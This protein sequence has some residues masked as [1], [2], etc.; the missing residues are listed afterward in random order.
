MA[1]MVTTV[2]RQA[3]ISEVLAPALLRSSVTPSHR[4]RWKLIFARAGFLRGFAFRSTVSIT[5]DLPLESV[6]HN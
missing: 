2:L 4:T 3:V 6:S 5:L 1:I